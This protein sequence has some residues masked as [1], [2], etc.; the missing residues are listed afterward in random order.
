MVSDPSGTLPA[1][2]IQRIIGN[3]GKSGVCL[4]VPPNALKIP[5]PDLESWRLVNHRAYDQ[6]TEDNFSGTSVHLSFTEYQMA[7]ELSQH[8]QRDQEAYYIGA[9]VSIHDR[10]CWIADIDITKCSMVWLSESRIK[11]SVKAEEKKRRLDLEREFTALFDRYLSANP[12]SQDEIDDIDFEMAMRDGPSPTFERLFEQ[13]ASRP[14]PR[15]RPWID[16]N[17]VSPQNDEMDE[18]PINDYQPTEPSDESHDQDSCRHPQADLAHLWPLTSIDS[19]AELLDPRANNA[20]VRAHR[21]R[22]AR[23]CAAAVAVQQGY[24]VHVVKDGLCWQCEYKGCDSKAAHNDNVSVYSAMY[25][26]GRTPSEVERCARPAQ[27]L[28]KGQHHIFIW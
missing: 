13:E 23:L 15:V 8:G 5:K 6:K 18:I 25:G 24:N 14:F 16:E 9:I 28:P 17:R 10:G 12:T 20:I 3:I 1:Y 2:A 26:N 11:A 19:W 7:T 4:L 21:N 22:I 27:V